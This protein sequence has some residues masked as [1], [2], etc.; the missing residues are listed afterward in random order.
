[1]D[2]FGQQFHLKMSQHLS[3]ADQQLREH[4]MKIVH[5]KV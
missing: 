3:V 2:T 4:I 5:K 1:M